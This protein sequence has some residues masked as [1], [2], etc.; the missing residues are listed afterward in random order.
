MDAQRFARAHRDVAPVER[1]R[2][3]AGQHVGE[4]LALVRVRR[5]NR[6]PLQRDLRDLILAVTGD[7][8]PR[9]A[10]A[11]LLQDDVVPPYRVADWQP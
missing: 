2:Q 9:D 5:N 11:D 1:E 6:A 8:F 7:E 3:R 4:L 10:V